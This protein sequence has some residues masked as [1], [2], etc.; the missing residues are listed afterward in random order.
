MITD[1]DKNEKKYFNNE[2]QYTLQIQAKRYLKLYGMILS[3][4]GAY[5]PDRQGSALG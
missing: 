5:L 2:Q 3:A 4:K 1:K